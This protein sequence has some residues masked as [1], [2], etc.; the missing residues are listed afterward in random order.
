MRYSCTEW[1]QWDHVDNGA[2]LF[3]ANSNKA[4]TI[5]AIWNASMDMGIMMPMLVETF[6]KWRQFFRLSVK[7]FVP[8]ALAETAPGHIHIVSLINT[9]WDAYILFWHTH[10]YMHTGFISFQWTTRREFAYCQSQAAETTQ[11]SKV[12]M[13]LLLHLALRLHVGSVCSTCWDSE[14][15]I[16]CPPKPPRVLRLSY[17][18]ACELTT[19]LTKPMCSLPRAAPQSPGSWAVLSTHV[20][21]IRY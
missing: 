13:Q 14:S 1:S 21:V 10:T 20:R 15:V 6:L 9:Y 5:S 19:G 8:C 2:S 4:H 11:G 17:D 3:H 7:M 18:A 12:K 16:A